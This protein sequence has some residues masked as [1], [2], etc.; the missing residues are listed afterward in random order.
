M[1]DAPRPRGRFATTRWSLVFAAG[2]PGD[3]QSEE[4]LAKLCEL[5][6]HPVYAAM[7]R[8]G[9]GT[10]EAGDLTQDFFARVLEK[11]YFRDAD[12][13][14]G[15]FRAFLSGAIKNFVSN[16]RDRSRT[17]K[18]GGRHVIVPL[19]IETAEGWYTVEARDDLTPE[20]VFDRQWALVV[21]DRVLNRL[22]DKHLA[23]GRGAQFDQLRVFLNGRGEGASY[24][25]VA[26]ALG[27]TEG[28]VKVA[29]HRLRRQFREVLVA[30][31]ADTVTSQSDIDGE[32]RHL[33]AAVSV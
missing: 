11:H 1:P 19:E 17:V 14:R 18:R 16:E 15:R 25:E 9:F 13:A 20:K 2:D 31:I 32:I 6:W 27:T 24:A 30:E 12:P 21:L 33:M 7:R 8:H 22:R 10:D 26:R 3:E 4:A 29:V 28:A 23:E 5:Y